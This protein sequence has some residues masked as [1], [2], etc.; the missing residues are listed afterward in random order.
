MVS[1]ITVG[2]FGLAAAYLAPLT[3]MLIKGFDIS[4]TFLRLGVGVL[5][6]AL[7]LTRLVDHRPRG[8]VAE[9]PFFFLFAAGGTSSAGSLCLS[10]KICSKSM[11]SEPEIGIWMPRS[12]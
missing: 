9:A 4:Q 7:P 6:V 3:G 12:T 8:Y 11:S 1:G 5:A 2:G 10:W